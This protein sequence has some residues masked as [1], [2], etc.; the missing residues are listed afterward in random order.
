MRATSERGWRRGA[1][2]GDRGSDKGRL[3]SPLHQT[4]YLALG[5]NTNTITDDF[6]KLLASLCKC[7][8]VTMRFWPA[9]VDETIR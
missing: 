1:G 9:P 7:D 2:Q 5:N 4:T 8:R 6:Q 3:G